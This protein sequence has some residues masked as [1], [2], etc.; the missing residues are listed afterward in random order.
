MQGIFN[1]II[2]NNDFLKIRRVK[3]H[4]TKKMF[5]NNLHHITQLKLFGLSEAENG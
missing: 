2:K 4:Q 3:N 1:P 5:A